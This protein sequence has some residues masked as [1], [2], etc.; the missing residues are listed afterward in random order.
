MIGITEKDASTLH[1]KS[2]ANHTTPEREAAFK[3]LKAWWGEFEATA[4]VAFQGR[5]DLLKLLEA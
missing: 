5:T 4:R 1:L 3:A 2:A